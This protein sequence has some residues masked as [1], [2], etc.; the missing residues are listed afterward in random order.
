MGEMNEDK[1]RALMAL[2]M[3]KAMFDGNNEAVL[4]DSGSELTEDEVFEHAKKVGKL[5]MACTEAFMAARFTRE[6]AFLLAKT[7]L[8]KAV[9]GSNT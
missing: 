4:E 9:E 8:E 1:L 7:L 3:L 2:G 6:E 5:L